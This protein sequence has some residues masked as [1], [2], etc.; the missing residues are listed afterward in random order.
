MIGTIIGLVLVLKSLDDPTQIGPKMS[1]AL[2]STFYGVFGCYAVFTPIAKKLERKHKD[3]ILY[4]HMVVKGIVWLQSGD[5]P[6]VL[7]QKM[8]GFMRENVRT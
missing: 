7:A 2:L 4:R 1:L 5:S 3:E 6:K 8:E